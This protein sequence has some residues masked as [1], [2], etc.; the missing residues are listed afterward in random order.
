MVKPQIAPGR[1]LLSLIGADQYLKT[2]LEKSVTEV[3]WRTVELPALILS[4]TNDTP[5]RHQVGWCWVQYW[6]RGNGPLFSEEG[7]DQRTKPLPETLHRYKVHLVLQL[8]FGLTAISKPVI[9][10]TKWLYLII[11]NWDQHWD[12]FWSNYGYLATD[13]HVRSISGAVILKFLSQ[14]AVRASVCC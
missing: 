10:Q 4:I 11:C 2:M 7:R 6:A 13:V 1:T 14:Q 8:V 5:I 9:D 12:L 3:D